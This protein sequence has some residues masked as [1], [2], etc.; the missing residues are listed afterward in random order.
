MFSFLLQGQQEIGSRSISALPK[1]NKHHSCPRRLSKPPPELKTRQCGGTESWGL[2]SEK[3]QPQ[4]PPEGILGLQ[5][6]WVQPQ[7]RLNSLCHSAG[8]SPPL[9]PGPCMRSYSCHR[10]WPSCAPRLLPVETGSRNQKQVPTAGG[11]NQSYGLQI[12]T[13]SEFLSHDPNTHNHSLGGD[14]KQYTV[15]TQKGSPE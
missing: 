6:G 10:D 15:P 14:K 11:K 3:S 7:P 12:S 5:D 1:Q 9:L 8:P 13:F 2:K 4:G